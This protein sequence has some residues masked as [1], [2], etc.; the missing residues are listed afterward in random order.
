MGLQIKSDTVVETKMSES[1]IWLDLIKV[2]NDCL[3]SQHKENMVGYYFSDV[4]AEATKLKNF[5]DNR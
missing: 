1:E 4:I 5:I 2:A 3:R